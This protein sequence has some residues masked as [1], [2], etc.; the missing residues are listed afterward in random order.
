MAMVSTS[1]ATVRPATPRPSSSRMP[2]NASSSFDKELLKKPRSPEKPPKQKTVRML[3]RR[4]SVEVPEEAESLKQLIRR[5]WPVSAFRFKFRL[6]K[7]VVI[8][9]VQI[10][11]EFAHVR[12][13]AAMV[14]GIRIPLTKKMWRRQ[15]QRLLS[16]LPDTI[17]ER[18]GY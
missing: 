1:L 7:R 14:S 16:R 5:K 9:P 17:C 3:L 6:M 10:P 15:R 18:I 13:W 4:G 12:A 8:P 11:T 2:F